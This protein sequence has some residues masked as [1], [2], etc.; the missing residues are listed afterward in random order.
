[1]VRGAGCREINP[2]LRRREKNVLDK[3]F[4]RSGGGRKMFLTNPFID[5]AAASMEPRYEARNK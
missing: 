1:M 4:Y 2:R 3:S 5:Q